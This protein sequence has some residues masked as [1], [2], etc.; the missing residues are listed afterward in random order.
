MVGAVAKELEPLLV[1][2]KGPFYGGSENLT[3][4]EVYM[5]PRLS[6][7]GQSVLVH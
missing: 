2:G 4:A 7:P 6:L 5:P 1:G 3:L